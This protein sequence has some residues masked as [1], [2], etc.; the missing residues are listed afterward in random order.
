MTLIYVIVLLTEIASKLARTHF[1]L[2]PSGTATLTLTRV[3]HEGRSHR[4]ARR[5][6]VDSE[7]PG[8]DHSAIASAHVKG[9]FRM[10]MEYYMRDLTLGKVNIHLTPLYPCAP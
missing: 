10:D 8:S 9:T 3:W 6:V 2:S 4:S 7:G 1:R 5:S